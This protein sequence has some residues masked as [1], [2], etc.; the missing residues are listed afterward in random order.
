MG[1]RLD[2]FSTIIVMLSP[3]GKLGAAFCS[4][5]FVLNVIKSAIK[6]SSHL[7]KLRNELKSP[8][9]G[10]SRYAARFVAS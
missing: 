9:H 2:G 10:L 4:W 8:F 3:V 7:I 1:I 5:L 6:K